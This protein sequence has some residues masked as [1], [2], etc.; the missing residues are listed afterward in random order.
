MSIIFLGVSATKQEI[1]VTNT[2][3]LVEEPETWSTDITPDHLNKIAAYEWIMRLKVDSTAK[4]EGS[5]LTC[6]N[7]CGN[8]CLWLGYTYKN[9]TVEPG[10]FTW[11]DEENAICTCTCYVIR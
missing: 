10:V 8:R 1:Q 4:I 6:L 3:K 2:E 7:V 11:G 5:E 9:H